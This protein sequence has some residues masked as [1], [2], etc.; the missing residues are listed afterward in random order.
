MTDNSSLKM[1][2]PEVVKVE[3]T[4]SKDLEEFTE[5]HIA[6]HTTITRKH[7]ASAK[8]IFWVKPEENLYTL[9]DRAATFAQSQKIWKKEDYANALRSIITYM[10]LPI[11][12]NNDQFAKAYSC[13]LSQ[14][15][16]Q[17]LLNKIKVENVRRVFKI[18]TDKKG[19]F[20]ILLK[21][22]NHLD[23]REEGIVQQKNGINYIV[24][25]A[26][27]LIG[28]VEL[29]QKFIFPIDDKAKNLATN[30]MKKFYFSFA[31]I[32]KMLFKGLLYGPF[33]MTHHNYSVIQ[34]AIDAMP[35]KYSDDYKDMNNWD[36]INKIK[37]YLY[38]LFT[39]YLVNAF[40]HAVKRDVPKNSDF[41]YRTS[42]VLYVLPT[43]YR[44]I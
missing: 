21:S 26:D 32:A 41:K 29:W 8:A 39:D 30:K 31:V 27:N 37:A 12:D 35:V 17:T 20:F 13:F 19:D 16:K 4:P 42:S 15:D 38:Q 3:K 36:D 7:K 9:F 22:K 5:F 14:D 18:P 11:S 34:E 33:A 1:F 43:K 25:N 6:E 24:F 44:N 40:H 2:I 10:D 28:K 23:I